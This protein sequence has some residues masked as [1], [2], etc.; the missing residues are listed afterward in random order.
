[1]LSR[2]ASTALCAYNIWASQA[3]WCIFAEDADVIGYYLNALPLC[4]MAP[5]QSI[6][7]QTFTGMVMEQT[8][9]Q[10]AGGRPGS[11][12]HREKGAVANCA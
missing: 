2:Q 1:M 5:R 9:E 6:W 3:N 8:D 7:A 12:P 4:S 10:S 11:W